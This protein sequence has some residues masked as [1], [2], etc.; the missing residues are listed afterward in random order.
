MQ[1]TSE[2][3][4][5]KQGK[6]M[7]HTRLC[8]M[9]RSGFHLPR[10]CLDSTA[11]FAKERHRERASLRRAVEEEQKKKQK[12][13]KKKKKKEEEDKKKN[14]QKKTRSRRSRRS[15]R[16]AEEAEENSPMPQSPKERK[17]FVS[18]ASS[19]HWWGPFTFVPRHGCTSASCLQGARN[20]KVRQ[21]IDPDSSCVATCPGR[22][23]DL[24]EHLWASPLHA[25]VGPA[26][27]G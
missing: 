2:N 6:D 20:Y 3:S 26:F 22:R 17:R 16:E 5:T 15:R 19:F 10:S 24:A 11:F 25:D 1:S 18:R 12:K 27:L 4:L 7:T 21:Q 8:E 9:P 23:D 13:K 14:N